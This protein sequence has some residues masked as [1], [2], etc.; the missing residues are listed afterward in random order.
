MLIDVTIIQISACGGVGRTK[1]DGKDRLRRLHL[2]DLQ[3]HQRDLVVIDR[4][5]RRLIDP[6]IGII[7]IIR[8]LL[9][10]EIQIIEF[11]IKNKFSKKKQR[12]SRTYIICNGVIFLA[13][14]LLL[15]LSSRG[16]L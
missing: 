14:V 2:T 5:I 11:L 4:R 15:Y 13:S 6:V 3:I 7:K 9:L 12:I 10:E 16:L 1:V 8:L